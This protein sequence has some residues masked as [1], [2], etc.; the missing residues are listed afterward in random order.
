[1]PLLPE[2]AE[3][4]R[5][6]GNGRGPDDPVFKSRQGRLARTQCSGIVKAIFHRAGVMNKSSD[7]RL[8]THTLRKTFG[9][10]TYEAGCD[11]RTIQQL[12]RHSRNG[13]ITSRYVGISMKQLQEALE[14]YSPLR[15]IDS[16]RT[17][18]T[19]L[20]G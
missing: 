2:T 19:I 5:E 17:R 13:D 16:S 14:T 1:M 6:L 12:M 8:S 10:L 3:I 15:Q 9:T 7:V 18:C 4:L 11:Y 20:S